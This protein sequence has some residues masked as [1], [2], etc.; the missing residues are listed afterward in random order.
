MPSVARITLDDNCDD[1]D[2]LWELHAKEAGKGP[3]RKFHVEILNKAI[4]LFVC[5][6]WEAY[7]EDVI[8]EAMLH[9]VQDCTDPDKLPETLRKEVAA[10]IHDDKSELAPWKLS[11][12]GWRKI[13]RDN[14]ADAIARLTGNWN[15]PKSSQVRD[16]FR[17]ALGIQDIT[18][19]WY[20]QKG[21][22]KANT[23]NLDKWVAL[24]G[25]IAHRAKTPHSVKKKFGTKFFNLV[26]L[27]ADKI[28]HD[29]SEVLEVATGKKYW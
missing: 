9:I 4:V 6:L 25:E 16:L 3:G 19:S 12:D 15:T 21:S 7:C 18:S 28:D 26:M 23:A 8:K 17:K 1:L 14:A 27:L 20:W 22:V 24:R 11:A 10:R 29:V 2:R 5:A 13:V